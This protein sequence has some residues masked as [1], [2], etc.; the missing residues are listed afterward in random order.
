MQA[1]AASGWAEARLRTVD[2]GSALARA[3]HERTSACEG[4]GRDRGE[5]GRT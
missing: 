5:S 2:C 3:A 4:E 1:M